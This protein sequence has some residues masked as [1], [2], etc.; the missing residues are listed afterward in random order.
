MV[1]KW[2]LIGTVNNLHNKKWLSVCTNSI[3]LVLILIIV[4]TK[5]LAQDFRVNEQREYYTFADP[6]VALGN[7]GNSVIVWEQIYGYEHRVLCQRFDGNGVPIGTQFRINDEIS[8]GFSKRPQIAMDANE[9]FVI[10]WLDELHDDARKHIFAQHYDSFGIA[11]GSKIRVTTGHGLGDFAFD[12]NSRGD[13]VVAIV[14]GFDIIHTWYYDSQSGTLIRRD[15]GPIIISNYLA[16]GIDENGNY[17]VVLH[18]VGSPNNSKSDIV[19]IRFYHSGQPQRYR[20]NVNNV[21][22]GFFGSPTIN[23]D[24]DGN[25]VIAWEDYQDGRFDIYAQ[26]FDSSA[27][28]L[29]SNF[30]VNSNARVNRSPEIGMDGNGNYIIAWQQNKNIYA[31]R[32]FST[33]ETLGDNYQVTKVVDDIGVINPAISRNDKGDFIIAWEKKFT[34]NLRRIYGRDHWGIYSQYFDA[35][36]ATHENNLKITADDESRICRNPVISAHS[37]QNFVIAWQDGR[38]GNY[39]IYAQRYQ[40]DSIAV[41][42]NFR[43]NDDVDSSQQISPSIGKDLA[44]NFVIIWQDGRN[45]HSDIYGQRYN[46]KGTKLG[47]NFRINDNDDYNNQKSPVICVQASG[48]FLVV[49]EDERNGNSDIYAQ[50]FNPSGSAQGDNFQIND[51]VGNLSQHNPAAVVDGKGDF[52][53]TWEDERN[54]NYDIYAQRLNS[55]GIALGTNF[56]VIDVEDASNQSNPSIGVNAVGDFTIVWQDVRNGDSDIYA[57]QL[58][59]NGKTL[60][61][62]FRVNDDQEGNQQCYPSITMNKNGTSY[63]VWQDDRN[64]DSDI[65]GQQLIQNGFKSGSNFKINI[66]DEGSDQTFPATYLSKGKLFTTW[67]NEEVVGLE[68]NI[69]ATVLSLDTLAKSGNFDNHILHQNYPNPFNSG[70]TIHFNLPLSGHLTLR[71]YNVNGQ[72]IQ[73]LLNEWKMAGSYTIYWNG[74]NENGQIV[75]NGLY[76][77]KLKF[78]N[79]EETRRMLLMK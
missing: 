75:G 5:T 28:A 15:I 68:T 66:D 26:R 4:N 50:F 8:T 37:G 2:R 77:C 3:I 51:D 25:F 63:I 1:F 9:N 61:V 69:I 13:F 29:G 22:I 12:M 42:D 10:I 35:D 36:G 43:V 18:E 45:R 38:N 34:G 20:F 21:D 24:S 7:S 54:G 17:V 73:I 49:W 41:G 70:T 44:G 30:R 27:V 19:A 31:Q 64:G 76:F 74:L 14:G 78:E 53:I 32:Y 40:A 62:N 58:N 16:I 11:L 39:D 6:Q 59:S 79:V 65:Y 23:M 48:K 46:F 55:N 71:I 57:Q 33:G 67:E 52:I 47:T 56:K 72:L 60:G